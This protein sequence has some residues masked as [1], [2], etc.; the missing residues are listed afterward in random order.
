MNELDKNF[1]IAI[2]KRI[3][4]IRK[5]LSLTIEELAGRCEPPLH[6]N[7]LGA[8]ER[9]EYNLSISGLFRIAGG[10]DV[11]VESLVKIREFDDLEKSS[12]IDEMTAVASGMSNEQIDFI[13]AVMKEVKKRFQ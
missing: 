1:A 3:R 7:Y 13:I 11:P 5:S 12:I 2:G 9:G 10:L 6:Y 4:E 8:V